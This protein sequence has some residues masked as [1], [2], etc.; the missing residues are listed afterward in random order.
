MREVLRII[1]SISDW[2]GKVT[3]FIIAFLIAGLLYEI[4]ARYVFN[5]PTI[6]AHESSQYLFA[7]YAFLAGGYCLRH[8]LHINMDVVYRRFSPRTKAIVD[9]F[10]S[11]LALGFII[12]LLWWGGITAWESVR[13]REVTTTIWAPPL[14]PFKVT[15]P[16]GA[17]LLLLQWVAKFVRDVITAINPREAV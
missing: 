4:V 7:T 2:S 1:D 12:S 9:L 5:N 17:A 3:S 13:L 10:T 15:L 8:G 16:L 14:Y 11:W 6:W